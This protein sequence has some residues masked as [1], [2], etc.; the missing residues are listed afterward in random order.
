ME[1]KEEERRG[2]RQEEEGETA[3][4]ERKT[5][6]ERHRE[7]VRL[8]PVHGL[9]YGVSPARIVRAAPP[10]SVLTARLGATPAIVHAGCVWTHTYTHVHRTHTPVG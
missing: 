9:H 4:W 1:E 5:E 3:G 10:R 6:T 8:G 2:E 7:T